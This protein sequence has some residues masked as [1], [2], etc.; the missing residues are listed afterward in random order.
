MVS[1]RLVLIGIGA[2]IIVPTGTPDDI[3]TF[4]II[5]KLGL[6]LYLLLLLLILA[7]IY[8]YDVKTKR[9]QNELKSVWRKIKRWFA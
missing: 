6:A 4:Y 1:V 3:I 5:Q 7:Y 2:W 9:I 8:S